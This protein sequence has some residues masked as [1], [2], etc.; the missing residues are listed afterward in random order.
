M[1]YWKQ[2]LYYYSELR[3]G[4]ISIML[5]ILG[6]PRVSLEQTS[7]LPIKDPAYIFPCIYDPRHLLVI[8]AS[9]K[10]SQK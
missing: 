5:D 1:K 3:F 10:V 7:A 2:F 9:Y 8:R 6:F 4:V